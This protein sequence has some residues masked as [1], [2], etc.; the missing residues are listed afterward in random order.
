VAP[1]FKDHALSPPGLDPQLAW[2]RANCNVERWVR[3]ARPAQMFE[4]HWEQLLSAPEAVLGGLCARLG[5]RFDAQI[6]AAM[7]EYERWEFWGYGPRS[8]PYGLDAQ[9]LEPLSDE[10]L[11]QAFAAPAL[12]RALPWREDGAGFAS[13]VLK[14]ATGFGYA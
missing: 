9:A 7:L 10:V 5:L 2:L 4:L 3:H 6:A 13:E 1:D 14:L 8:A 12:D 11:D